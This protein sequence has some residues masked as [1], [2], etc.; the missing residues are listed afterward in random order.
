MPFLE[1]LRWPQIILPLNVRSSGQDW[2]R[3]GASPAGCR[4]WG[5]AGA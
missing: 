1:S 3:L 2:R 5:V 4:T